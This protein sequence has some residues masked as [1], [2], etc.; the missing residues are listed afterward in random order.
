MATER[1]SVPDAH[2]R[3]PGP[4]RAPAHVRFGSGPLCNPPRAAAASLAGRLARVAV[5]LDGAEVIG[6]AI[7][8]SAWLQRCWPWEVAAVVERG[9]PSVALAG[10]LQGLDVLVILCDEIG[11][12]TG[13]LDVIVARG[14][15]P[16]RYWPPAP[17]LSAEDVSVSVRVVPHGIHFYERFAPNDVDADAVCRWIR[18]AVATLTAASR[19]RPPGAVRATALLCARCSA[20]S[21]RRICGVCGAEAPMRGDR[22]ARILAPPVWPVIVGLMGLAACVL[23]AI[24]IWKLSRA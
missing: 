8:A 21:R 13:S 12:A 3:P 6:D 5:T 11:W 16:L 20:R 22:G 9:A 15:A 18:E 24:W 14:G 7:R 10:K 17:T 23:A 2:L 19:T 1:F 4:E